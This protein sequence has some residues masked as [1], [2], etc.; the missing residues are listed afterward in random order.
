MWNSIKALD[1]KNKNSFYLPDEINCPN[2]IN[3][4]FLQLSKAPNNEICNFYQSRLFTDF[5]NKFS[6]SLIKSN[7]MGPDNLNIHMLLLCSP[8]IIKV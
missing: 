6:F 7:A 1:I 5:E 3:K 4:Y 2:D 8:K